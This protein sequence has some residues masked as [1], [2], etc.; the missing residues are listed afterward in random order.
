MKSVLV[1]GFVKDFQDRLNEALSELSSKVIIDVKLTA[2]QGSMGAP[3]LN[4]IIL[5]KE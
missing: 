5:Y 4:A 3:I 1:T 2:A